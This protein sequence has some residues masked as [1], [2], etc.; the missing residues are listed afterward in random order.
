M[1]DADKQVGGLSRDNHAAPGRQDG[2]VSPNRRNF[3]LPTTSA[4]SSRHHWDR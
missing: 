3:R 2:G 1:P 4:A